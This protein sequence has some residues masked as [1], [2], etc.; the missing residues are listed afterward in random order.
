LWN[1]A[2]KFRKEDQAKAVESTAMSNSSAAPAP[3]PGKSARESSISL[4]KVVR[5]PK[6]DPAAKASTAVLSVELFGVRIA[7]PTGFDR[8]T[9]AMVLDEIEARRVRLGGR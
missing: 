2:A 5:L 9:F 6:Q 4:A 7:V 3:A 8:L 1:W